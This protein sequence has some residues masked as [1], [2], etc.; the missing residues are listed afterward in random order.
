MKIIPEPLFIEKREGNPLLFSKKITY[1]QSSMGDEIFADFRLF[2]KKFDCACKDA[3]V[4]I[5]AFVDD[6]LEAEEYK[7]A[8]SASGVVI[9]AK[10]AV[11]AFYALQTLKQ[12]IVE[13]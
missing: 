12:L 10:A 6:R 3:T 1:E 7:L 5:K 11:G 13:Y 2:M 8:V 4:F 9:T